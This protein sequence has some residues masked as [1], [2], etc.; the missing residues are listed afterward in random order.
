LPETIE[1]LITTN[2]FT[3]LV[4]G[5]GAGRGGDGGDGG[6][7]GEGGRPGPNQECSAASPGDAGAQGQ[8]G[9]DGPDGKAGG[10]GSM[11]VVRVFEESWNEQLTR[12]W[13]THLTPTDAFPG[14][15]ITVRGLQ[16]ADT[17][18]VVVGKGT[19]TPKVRADG[20]L[21]FTLANDISGGTHTVFVR[22]FSGEESNHL[23]LAVRPH[24]DAGQATIAPGVV[25]ALTGQAFVDGASVSLDGELY[26]ANVANRNALTFTT[27]GI[28]GPVNA[29]RQLGIRVVNPDGR[30]SNEVTATQP[31][32]LENGFKLGV[33]DYKFA[34]FDDGKP[35]MKGF[36]ETFGK[37]EV[38]HEL[39]D[40]IFGHPI[41]TAAFFVFYRKYLKGEGKGGLSTG[42]CTA[43]ASTA[44]DRFW[45]GHDDTFATVTKPPIHEHL[46]AVHGR[47]LSR[48][49]LL[50]M[51][52][53]GRL[54]AANI[55]PTFRTIEKA[56]LSGGTRETAPLL[57]FIPSGE[58]WDAGYRDKLARSHCV[59]PIKITYPAGYDGK[60]LHGVD[61]QVWDNN[62][63]K[64][65]NCRVELRRSRGK[66]GFRFISNGDVKYGTIDGVTI[67]TQSLGEYLLSDVDLP[68]SGAFGLQSFV[69]DF[70]L[71]PA[72]LSVVD[73]EKR[74]TGHFSDKILAE[75][76]GSLPGYLAPGMFLLPP[77]TGMVR[78]I[79]GTGVGT[80]DYTSINPSGVSLSISDV[81][82]GASQVDQV[83]INAD[84]TQTQFIPV[85][86]KTVNA[87]VATEFAGQA[88]G[89]EI[90][91]FHAGISRALDITCTP[92]LAVVR[93][94][95]H[96]AQVTLPVKL[97]GVTSI[98]KAKVTRDL[99]TINVPADHE[100]VVAVENW[101][102]LAADDVSATAVAAAP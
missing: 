25:V 70:L 59:V 37:L 67:G 8:P 9:A 4:G 11:L 91:G 52:D 63:P 3:P 27:P 31:R 97:L 65:P 85:F 1:E 21:D 14:T 44:L 26:A 80:Y 90:R 62:V 20:G 33:H 15:V 64:N 61:I 22:R 7:G 39:L 47:L 88:R 30:R 50:T 83:A 66:L 45:T 32:I 13:I 77:D 41:L 99:G 36:E 101:G 93:I 29:E 71:S 89:I 38:V 76:P 5:G 81:P 18:K 2:K 87:T 23:K 95:N 43:L 12:P 40:P 94:A 53:Q 24:L 86:P 6:K 42:F 102:G 92:D 78:T 73:S 75:I 84:G 57:F 17:D 46:T 28:S 48:E 55:E 60:D 82:T 72:T 69:I 10:D 68:F 51:N 96:G 100:L 16:F 56:F 34:N 49:N 74:R 58:V 98:T 19:V 54:G 35:S 79:R